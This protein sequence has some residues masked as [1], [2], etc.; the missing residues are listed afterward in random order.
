MLAG[1]KPSV[2][3]CCCI[4]STSETL[5]SSMWLWRVVIWFTMA[6]LCSD[7]S[8]QQDI[9]GC[10]TIAPFCINGIPRDHQS[11]IIFCFILM[12]NVNVYWS[13][14][15]VQYLIYTLHCAVR[16]IIDSLGICLNEQVKMCSFKGTSVNV[17]TF[18]TFFFPLALV[19][20][21]I[22]VLW[23]TQNYYTVKAYY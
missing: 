21:F 22:P 2:V 8:Y 17:W 3:F 10:R 23:G 14:W 20:C 13:L 4:P 11:R 7:L 16:H 15:P 6:F 9:S 1:V 5:F 18:Y 12:L 19:F